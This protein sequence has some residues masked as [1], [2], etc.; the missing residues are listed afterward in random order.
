MDL[1]FENII[2]FMEIRYPNLNY[3][4]TLVSKTLT[5]RIDAN[6]KF[7]LLQKNFPFVT[8][9]DKE[10]YDKYQTNQPFDTKESLLVDLLSWHVEEKK[11]QQYNQEIIINLADKKHI[12]DRLELFNE[13]GFQTEIL[14]QENSMLKEIESFLKNPLRG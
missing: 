14:G 10:V 6:T 5:Q 9:D 13:V 12:L 11:I 4:S 2:K 7:E 3:Y 1:L 8:G